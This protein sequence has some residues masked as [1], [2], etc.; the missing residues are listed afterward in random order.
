[1]APTAESQPADASS[2][3]P[4]RAADRAEQ[5]RAVAARAVRDNEVAP[6]P[7]ESSGGGD[8]S[9]YTGPRCYA[10]GGKTWRPC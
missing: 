10:P 9:G 8:L 4:R 5:E 6:A 7:P 3:Q 1:M 2:A